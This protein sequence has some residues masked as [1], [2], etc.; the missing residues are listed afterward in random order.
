[1]SAHLLYPLE[2]REFVVDENRTEYSEG[3]KFALSEQLDVGITVVLEDEG[4]RC[5][6]TISEHSR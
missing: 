2:G 6:T 1:M 5:Q 3:D 4:Q